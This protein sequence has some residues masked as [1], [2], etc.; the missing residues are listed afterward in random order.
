MNQQEE[1]DVSVLRARAIAAA[2]KAAMPKDYLTNDDARIAWYECCRQ[3]AHVVCTAD[4]VSL[5][6]F[7][8]LCGV[9]D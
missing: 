4:G 6:T 3:V 9:P 1:K 2:L 8:D 5:L 7:Y